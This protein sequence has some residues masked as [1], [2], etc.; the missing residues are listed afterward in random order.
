VE[1]EYD[2]TFADA[3]F[4][5]VGA[6]QQ[7]IRQAGFLGG[8]V[9]DKAH[10]RG[11][12][13]SYEGLLSRDLSFYLSGDVNYARDSE[14][15]LRIAQIPDFD[16]LTTLQYLN[17]EGYYAQTAYYYQGNRVAAYDD[18]SHL[19]G[20]GVLN[21]RLGKRSGLRTNLYVELNNIL[22]KKYDVYGALQPSRQVA[23]GISQRF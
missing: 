17:R 11:L 21:L 6:F 5:R 4:L 2:R 9:Y 3:S 13:A 20:F 18:R 23:I 8:D 19:G 14:T 22:N 1:I 10:N 15:G 16:G 12:Q 7:D